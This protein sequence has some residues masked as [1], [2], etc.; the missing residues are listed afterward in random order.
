LRLDA[1]F[2]DGHHLR[3]D[4]LK[5]D[6][7]EWS[8]RRG[9]LGAAIR[10]IRHTT[11]EGQL[12]DLHRVSATAREVGTGSCV[13]R[14][15]VDR[16]HDRRV[17]AAGGAAVGVAGAAGAAAAATVVA[18][19]VILL[20]A[21]LAALAGFGIAANSRRRARRTEREIELLLDAINDKHDP[22]RLRSD[23]LRR[24]IGRPRHV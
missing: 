21:P 20:G 17:F 15:S 7:G 3:R 2:V 4:R 9:A 14:V 24:A 8:K 13:V 16:S 11:G 12:S 6:H 19:P 1:W 23:V 18:A 10:V 22:V 5:R